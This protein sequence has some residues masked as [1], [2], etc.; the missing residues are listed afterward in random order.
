[1]RIREGFCDEKGFEGELC[2][3]YL[4]LE[5]IT[6]QVYMYMQFLPSLQASFFVA[7][8]KAWM[9]DLRVLSQCGFDESARCLV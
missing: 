3:S 7:S 6:G 8:S 1:M 5:M 4:L 2:C 9:S